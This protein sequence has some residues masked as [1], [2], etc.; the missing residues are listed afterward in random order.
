MISVYYEIEFQDTKRHDETA[1]SEED[2]K[3]L[4]IIEESAKMKDGHYE[5]ALPWRAYPPELPNNKVAAERRLSLLK[6]RLT[7]DPLLHGKYSA[8][9]EDL[10]KK[11]YAQKVPQEKI[12][13]EAPAWPAA[14]YLPHRPVAH[15]QKPEKV[16]VVD[17]AAKYGGTCLNDVLLQG[18]YLTNTLVGVLT[19]FRQESTAVMADV[20]SM[21]YQ[22]HVRPEDSDY[23]R[24]LWCVCISSEVFRHPVARALG[25]GKPPTTTEQTLPKKQ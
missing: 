25:C 24:Y 5:I 17:C 12:S 23:L 7:K 9:M 16:R 10:Q 2:I 22:V 1:M 21:F 11:G 18:P 8:F 3:A 19:R 14:W 15:P 13:K 4:S 6:K 20:E